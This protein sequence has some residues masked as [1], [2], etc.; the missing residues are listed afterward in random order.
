MAISKD[1]KTNY[2]GQVLC[3]RERYWL[4]GMLEVWAVIWNPDEHKSEYITVGYYGSDCCNQAGYTWEIDATDEVK[5]D[6]LR[7]LKNAANQAYCDSV[8]KTKAK[9]TKGANVEVIRGRKVVKG[10]KLKIF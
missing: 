5:R 10:T 8:L 4:D 9:I 3:E 2:V 6:V 1:G 7:T